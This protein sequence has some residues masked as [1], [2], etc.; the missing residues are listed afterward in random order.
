MELAA[1]LVPGQKLAL[2][3]TS[4]HKTAEFSLNLLCLFV[5]KLRVLGRS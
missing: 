1:G 2:R 4:R 3:S 5:T